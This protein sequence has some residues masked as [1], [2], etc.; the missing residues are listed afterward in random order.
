MKLAFTTLGCPAW[1]MATI[2]SRAV[3]YGYDGVDFRG[4]QSALNVY[5]L[6]AFTTDVKDTAQ[7]FADAGL[8]LPCFSSSVS[9]YTRDNG[10][11]EKRIRELRAYAALCAHFGTR[12]IRIFG[13]AIGDTPRD[14]AIDV[15]VA[16][17][18][19]MLAVAK[20]HGVTLLLETH[21][22][23]TE[24]GPIRR[25]IDAANSPQLGVL[26]DV[27]HPYRVAGES[28]DQTWASLGRWIANTHWKDSA[29]DP[30]E[31]SG[32]RLCLMGE[33]DIPLKEIFA[34]LK[35]N[36]YDG[37]LTLEW[38]KRWHAGLAEPEVAFPQFIT[39]MHGLMA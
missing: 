27:H 23:W 14:Q 26:W 25:I 35:K 20:D 16:N 32:Y 38:E 19:P 2:I 39:F 21:D 9:V 24:C 10:E 22:D 29:L 8:A 13:G 33:G 15:F 3:A 12:F 37:W 28:P 11:L 17:L 34:C 18:A 6:P 4:C 7:R 30:A 5:E 1:D 36:G 31:K